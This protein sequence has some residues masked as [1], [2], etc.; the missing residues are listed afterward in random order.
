MFAYG[1]GTTV[2]EVLVE[3]DDHRGLTLGPLEHF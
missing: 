2:R 3:S 1:K